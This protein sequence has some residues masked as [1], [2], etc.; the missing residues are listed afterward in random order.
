M[1]SP[2]PAPRA[3]PTKPAPPRPPG[4]G[5]GLVDPGSN[6]IAGHSIGQTP[7]S[8]APAPALS[9][10]PLSSPPGRGPI[11]PGSN[12]LV[13][14]SIGNPVP[15]TLGTLTSPDT[16]GR[17]LVAAARMDTAPAKNPIE[18][19]TIAEKNSGYQRFVYL[20][21]SVEGSV[22]DWQGLRED[23]PAVVPLAA[24]VRA[25]L[26]GKL[27]TLS[28]GGTGVEVDFPEIDLGNVPK[29]YDV[30]V[31]TW[32]GV[33]DRHAPNKIQW[34]TIQTPTHVS[35]VKGGRNTLFQGP[36]I[37]AKLSPTQHVVAVRGSIALSD[38]TNPLIVVNDGWHGVSPYVTI[39]F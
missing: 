24:S 18:V 13:G 21:A 14:Y 12:A 17:V 29:D 34:V 30:V 4:T 23:P 39:R 33:A 15:P 11:D 31:G 1:P 3:A 22:P 9:M 37:V 27:S 8:P 20:G 25:L 38:G 10:A 28:N 36:Q 5:P 35:I 6:T 2:S 16:Q 32:Y 19:K 7:F 26:Y